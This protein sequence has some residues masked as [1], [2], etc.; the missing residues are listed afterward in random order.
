M[1]LVRL[2]ER[3]DVIQ[4]RDLPQDY[5]ADDVARLDVLGI[6]RRI[7]SCPRRY[8][9]GELAV[10][11]LDADKEWRRRDLPWCNGRARRQDLAGRGRLQYGVDFALI[12]LT[13]ENLERDLDFLAR[14]DIARINLRNLD[15][16]QRVGRID[17]C[18]HR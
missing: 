17:E 14:L 2:S 6:N 3:I 18:H 4:D 11:E 8:T 1:A 5:L 9:G 12:D 15:A 7:A 13:G 10:I 16:D